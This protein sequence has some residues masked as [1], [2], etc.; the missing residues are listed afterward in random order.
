MTIPPGT[1]RVKPGTAGR[2]GVRPPIRRDP[3]PPRRR[4]QRIEKAQRPSRP[5]HVAPERQAPDRRRHAVPRADPA[6]AP[7]GRSMTTC[8]PHVMHYPARLFC[9]VATAHTSDMV[10]SLVVGVADRAAPERDVRGVL[11]GIA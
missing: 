10:G 2:R 8:P 4:N 5:G 9:D 7:T 3:R 1:G 6:M 11:G